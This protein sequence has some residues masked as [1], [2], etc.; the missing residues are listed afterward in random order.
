M[1]QVRGV[2]DGPLAPYEVALRAQLAR[3]GYAE[4][5]VRDVVRA[6]A[7]LSGWLERADRTAVDLTPLVLEEFL[8]LRRERC[9]SELVARRGLGPVLRFLHGVEVA[10]D[11]READGLGPAA[12]LLGQY[13]AWLVGDRCLAAESVRCY[14]SQAKKFL[15]WLP[16]PLA[17]WRASQIPDKGPNKVPPGMEDDECK[18][19]VGS[20]ALSLR[21]K[22]RV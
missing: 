12:I 4:S 1:G 16:D 15:A 21:L 2:V 18:R 20:T 6:M 13:R 17:E 10:L 11:P 19:N 7:R 9:T 3:A 14:C 8:G 5:S 22:R